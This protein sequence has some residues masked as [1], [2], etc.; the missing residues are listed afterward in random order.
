MEGGRI[1]GSLVRQVRMGND[2]HR[3]DSLRFC[4]HPSPRFLSAR[5]SFEHGASMRGA[6]SSECE[7][8]R[9]EG[10][11]R[12]IRLFP[13][14]RGGLHEEEKTPRK[15]CVSRIPRR[16]RPRTAAH[17]GKNSP[18][19]GAC[20]FPHRASPPRVRRRRGRFPR[21]EISCS[22]VF[23]LRRAAPRRCP[24]QRPGFEPKGGGRVGATGRGI[25]FGLL[26]R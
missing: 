24:T 2:R 18:L 21:L 8:K 20:L 26:V 17:R 3:N 22:Q 1:E 16:P 23:S 11:S 25:F 19:V 5:S 13:T 6:R 7:T 4:S 14:R 9:D 12:T 15:R 10:L